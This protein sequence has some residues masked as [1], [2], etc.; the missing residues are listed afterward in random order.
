MRQAR[1]EKGGGGGKNEWKTWFYLSARRL[2]FNY[3]HPPLLQRLRFLSVPR[4]LFR[5]S[6]KLQ[7]YYSGGAPLFSSYSFESTRTSPLRL[8]SAYSLVSP[9]PQHNLVSFVWQQLLAW[10]VA[11]CYGRPLAF[12]CLPPTVT[13]FHDADSQSKFDMYVDIKVLS[14]TWK[15]SQRLHQL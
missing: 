12:T 11:L 1:I 2:F 6:P 4:C 3:S 9:R 13:S 14:K 7:P 8:S 10:F 15:A 5:L